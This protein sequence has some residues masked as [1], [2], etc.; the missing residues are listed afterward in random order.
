MVFTTW[1]TDQTLKFFS[2]EGGTSGGTTL[3]PGLFE[4]IAGLVLL[5]L[6]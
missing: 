6:L 4:C 2:R 1:L 5:L 3:Q